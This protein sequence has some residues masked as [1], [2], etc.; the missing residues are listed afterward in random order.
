VIRRLI[1]SPH[2]LS[3]CGIQDLEVPAGAEIIMG[4]ILPHVREPE[5]PFREFTGYASY[6][7]TQ[8]LFD[9]NLCAG[10]Y[11]AI[12]QVEI[13]GRDACECDVRHLEGG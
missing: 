13:A 1:C 6:R 8:N 9:N 4:E 10:R 5:G 3:K 11:L 2:F 7:S 12:V